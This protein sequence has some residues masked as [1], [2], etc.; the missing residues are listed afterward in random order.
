MNSCSNSNQKKRCPQT[1]LRNIMQDIWVWR[2]ASRELVVL[3]PGMHHDT[4]D[5]V[6]QCKACHAHQKQ[7][8]AEPLSC[9]SLPTRSCQ[10]VST[11]LFK[12]ILF[13]VDSY[14]NYPEV[15]KLSNQSSII[16]DISNDGYI[17]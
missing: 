17:C 6:K 11:Y 16:S 7:Q 3:W 15:I 10:K 5:L 12:T 14:S 13:I 2:S 9:H 8:M 4:A 1:Y